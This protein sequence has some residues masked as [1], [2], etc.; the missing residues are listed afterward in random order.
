VSRDQSMPKEMQFL[1]LSENGP[2]SP[3][4]SSCLPLDFFFQ[5]L[6]SFLQRRSLKPLPYRPSC[7]LLFR[8]ETSGFHVV[9]LFFLHVPT[10][11]PSRRSPPYFFPFQ[12]SECSL[13]TLQVVPTQ[14]CTSAILTSFVDLRA[15]P[16]DQY[17]TLIAKLR[18]FLSDF[19]LK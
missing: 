18:R 10:L 16:L 2:S 11:F 3:L 14:L 8:R 15:M 13:Y 19:F 5:Y 7:S 17:L 9:F 12:S 4:F 1:F 6:P